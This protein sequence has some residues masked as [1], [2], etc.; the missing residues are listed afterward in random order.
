MFLSNKN[1]LIIPNKQELILE[2]KQLKHTQLHAHT[3]SLEKALYV[4]ET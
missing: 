2:E 3:D 1:S 4:T